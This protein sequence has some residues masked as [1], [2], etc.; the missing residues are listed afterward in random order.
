MI[1]R[2]RRRYVDE[3]RPQL[4]RE[5]GIA[6]VMEVPQLVKVVV[7]S[8]VGEAISDQNAPENAARDLG[9]IT[10][11]KPVITRATR[12]I[13]NFSLRKGMRV[14]V[15]VTLRG[16]RMY[17]FVDRLFSIGIPR[18]RD[19]RGLSRRSFDGRGN[20][21]TGFDEQLIFPEIDYTK[22]DRVRGFQV[23]FVTTAINDAHGLALLEALGCPFQ[24]EGSMN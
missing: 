16:D 12:S 7:N 2:L 20:Y 6:N 22:I 17:H 18:V 13:S 11:Q 1:S 10:G 23:T 9:I 4:A 8:G 15:M 3:F 21:S 24:A 19:F 5:L 14:G